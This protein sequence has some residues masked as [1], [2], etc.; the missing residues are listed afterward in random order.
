MII[1]MVHKGDDDNDNGDNDDNHYD[2]DNDNDENQVDQPV[3]PPVLVPKNFPGEVR[4]ISLS[5]QILNTYFWY[6]NI[7]I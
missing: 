3:L 7:N 2:D 1:M 4:T 6:I 5:W